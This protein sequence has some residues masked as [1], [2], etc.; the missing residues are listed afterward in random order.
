MTRGVTVYNVMVNT[1]AACFN[2][3]KLVFFPTV[4]LI[5][6]WI[7]DEGHLKFSLGTGNYEVAY[8]NAQ[9]LVV[10]FTEAVWMHPC[11]ET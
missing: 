9:E 3:Q 2:I 11:L 4:Y 10:F 5:L 8:F 1:Y 7:I 6:Y